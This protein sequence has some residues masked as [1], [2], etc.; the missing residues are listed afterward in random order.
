MKLQEIKKLDDNQVRQFSQHFQDQSINSV[1]I[2]VVPPFITDSLELNEKFEYGIFT[3]GAVV[4]TS[5]DN[6]LSGMTIQ[7]TRRDEKEKLR[8]GHLLNTDLYIIQGEPRTLFR[9]VPP[10]EGH[11]QNFL[12]Y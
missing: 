11:K 2:S 9:V 4:S 1:N 3:S 12:G 6:T 5:K 10:F 8:G 7:I